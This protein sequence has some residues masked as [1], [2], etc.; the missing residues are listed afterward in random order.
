MRKTIIAGL[1]NPGRSYEQTRH[2]VGYKTVDALIDRWQTGPMQKSGKVLL[3]RLIR[4]DRELLLVKP[5][6]YM[7]NSGNAVKGIFEKSKQDLD[8]MI[9]IHDDLDLPIGRLRIRK[10]GG[11]GGHKGVQSIIDHLKT[12]DFIR[13]R[14][15]IDKPV[16]T[17]EV[18]D[19]VL[20]PFAKNEKNILKNVIERAVLGVESILSEGLISAMN[21]FNRVVEL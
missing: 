20:T 11:S 6:S 19:Y 5:L 8:S 14:I 13:I 17:N 7:N 18:T 21:A 3:T 16:D 4:E 15:G 1:G 12:K 2:N 9:V 10:N